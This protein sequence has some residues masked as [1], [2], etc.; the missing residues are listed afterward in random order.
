MNS[1]ITK[2]KDENALTYFVTNFLYTSLKKEQIKNTL[3][4]IEYNVIMKVT[5]KTT[6]NADQSKTQNV[7]EHNKVY[8]QLS[9]WLTAIIWAVGEPNLGYSNDNVIIVIIFIYNKQEQ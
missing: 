7:L 8:S 5:R 6:E 2:K 1:K 9:P 4:Q 3:S